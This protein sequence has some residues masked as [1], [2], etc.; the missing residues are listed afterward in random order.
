MLELERFCYSELGTFGKLFGPDGWTCYT[1]EKPWKANKI[2]ESCIPEGIYPLRKRE[3]AIIQRTT[4]G[5]YQEGWEVTE[6]P[7]RTYIMIHIANVEDDLEGCIGPGKNLGVV[8]NTWAVS[9]SGDSFDEFMALMDE[10]YPNG[11]DIR[12]H[13]YIPEYP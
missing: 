10:H 9:Y 6:V 7:N 2:R 3:S 13:Q 5:R 12:I 1:V 11:T 4:K 8:Y